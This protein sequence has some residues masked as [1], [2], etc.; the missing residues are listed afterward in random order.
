MQFRVMTLSGKVKKKQRHSCHKNQDNWYLWWKGKVKTWNCSLLSRAWLFENTPGFW[1]IVR[2]APLCPWNSPGKN[3]GVG[4]HSF[5]QGLLPTQG[6]NPGLLHCR[7]I[8]YLLNHQCSCS[9]FCLKGTFSFFS[10][11]SFILKSY[12][13]QILLL[14]WNFLFCSTDIPKES[15]Y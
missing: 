6:S 3:T 5:L 10:S 4:C 9:S 12:P 11:S 13:A 15:E 2:Q 8:L 7:Q 14:L 1:T